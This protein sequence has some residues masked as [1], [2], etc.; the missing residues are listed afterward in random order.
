MVLSLERCNLKE[1]WLTQHQ[2]AVL[3]EGLR[4]SSLIS[5]RLP[6]VAPDEELHFHGYEIPRGVSQDFLSPPVL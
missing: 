2:T 5:T 6:R 1:Q 4:L 3:K